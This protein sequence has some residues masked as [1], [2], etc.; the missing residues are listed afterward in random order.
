MSGRVWVAAVL[1]TTIIS[2][3][4]NQA[5]GAQQRDADLRRAG[6]TEGDLLARVP[7]DC[8]LFEA[9]GAPDDPNGDDEALG[10]LVA[11]RIDVDVDRGPLV[12]VEA[13]NNAGLTVVAA[14][15]FDDRSEQ[16]GEAVWV[17]EHGQPASVTASNHAAETISSA[18]LV[19]VD[20]AGEDPVAQAMA[21][22]QDCSAAAA[23]QLRPEP[24]KPPPS[25]RSELMVVD[26]T[27]VAAGE[28]VAMRFPKETMRGV[29]F[30]LDRW[31][32]ENWVTRYW[33]T[34]DGNGGQPM[35]VAVGTEG[36]EVVDVGVAGP[37]PDHVQIPDDATPGAYRICTANAGD[38]FC[39]PIEIIDEKQ[40]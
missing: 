30:Q 18:Q 4:G 39:A 40:R 10:E 15:L 14:T 33:M 2:G 34:S 29:A 17:V 8:R 20:T 37:G 38:E 1:A 19:A 28:T 11:S 3:C 9:A 24:P 36:Y 12:G 21:S 31:D 7:D 23:A 6:P 35:T 13:G 5:L 22:A 25:M 27:R 26:P 16:S 32:G